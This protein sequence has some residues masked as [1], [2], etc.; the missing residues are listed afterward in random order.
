[1]LRNLSGVEAEAGDREKCAWRVAYLVS[2]MFRRT[3]TST[4]IVNEP[5]VFLC[6]TNPSTT[7]LRL[8]HSR[9]NHNGKVAD[10]PELTARQDRDRDSSAVQHKL[11]PKSGL[12]KLRGGQA[13]S[14]PS[15]IL[16]KLTRFVGNAR[17][18]PLI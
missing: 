4:Q 2:L 6:I 8:C 7:N 5:S 1:M 18:P 15:I 16:S 11:L 17:C 9:C 13:I 3:A 12:E 14:H 10:T